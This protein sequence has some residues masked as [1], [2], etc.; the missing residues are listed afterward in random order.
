MGQLTSDQL[1]ALQD[2]F[3]QFDAD[4]DGRIDEDEFVELLNHLG[5]ELSAREAV[6]GFALIDT[7]NSGAIDFGEFAAWWAEQVP[8]SPGDA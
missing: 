4:S 3:D 2:V 8:G 1:R 5:S 7:D 6:I